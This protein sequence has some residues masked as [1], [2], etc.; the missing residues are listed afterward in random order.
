M[1]IPFFKSKQKLM[2]RHPKAVSKS[3]ENDQLMKNVME[4]H[5]KLRR[6][7]RLSQLLL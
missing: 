2:N 7:A 6:S 5:Q 1:K 4:A 3:R